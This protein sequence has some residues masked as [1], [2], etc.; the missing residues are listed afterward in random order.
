MDA[1]EYSGQ[2]LLIQFH[3]YDHSF[4]LRSKAPKWMKQAPLTQQVA[5][6]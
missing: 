2:S 1:T 6:C 4:P 5:I 3:Y